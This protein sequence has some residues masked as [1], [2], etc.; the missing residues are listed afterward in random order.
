MKI[1]LSVA[2]VIASSLNFAVAADNYPDKPIRLVV[3]FPPGGANDILARTL[4]PKLTE[5]WGQQIL[6][7]N[8]PGAGGNIGADV[9]A[10]A[11]PDGYTLLLGYTGNLTIS[12][13]LYANVPYNTL[14]DFAPVTNLVNQPIVLL[15]H[16]SFPAQSV[17]ELI[18]YARARPGQ[19]SYGSPGIGTAQHLAGE[20]FKH[21]AGID[22]IHVPYKGAVPS[23]AELIGGQIP[24]LVV[25]LAPAIPQIR[26]G[27]VRALAV[28]GA[29]R[30][31][32]LPD[33]P[34][35]GETLAG[36]QVGSW[37]GVLAPA[38]TAPAIIARLHNEIVRVLRLDDVRQH[39]E[40]AG[41]EIVGSSPEQFA[42]TIR[43]DLTKWTGV[44]R[45]A[46]IKPE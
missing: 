34:T 11:K 6:I 4:G 8:R 43:S 2:I 9:V 16:P 38:G 45:V 22:L 18:A 12:P 44:I 15:A 37:N 23:L 14:N 5:S 17:R 10:K 28:V 42:A 1:L 26:S 33:V 40:T 29:K 19:L 24:L 3:P 27:K 35:V 7:D 36:Y 21:R 39:L 46:G 20:L 31:V 25:G 30:A 41:F 13:G 32:V